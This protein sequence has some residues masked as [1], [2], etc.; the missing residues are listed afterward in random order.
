MFVFSFS[1]N[2]LNSIKL[3]G[4]WFSCFNQLWNNR[5]KFS[6]YDE[7]Q[8]H[9]NANINTNIYIYVRHAADEDERSTILRNDLHKICVLHIFFLLSFINDWENLHCRVW[10]GIGCDVY[11]AAQLGTT[12]LLAAARPPRCRYSHGSIH[13]CS[14]ELDD[15]KIPH[16][17]CEY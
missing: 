5:H 16:F 9:N 10:H 4:G 17:E 6:C 14:L 11:R 8:T 1:S 3:V 13:Q 7:R 2:Q 15:W 12:R